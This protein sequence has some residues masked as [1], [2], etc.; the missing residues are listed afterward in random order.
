MPRLLVKYKD[1]DNADSAEYETD[2]NQ[3]L[4]VYRGRKEEILEESSIS[5]LDTGN[6]LIIR[7]GKKKLSLN[8]SELEEL[9][10]LLK[11]REIVEKHEFKLYEVKEF[12]NDS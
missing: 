10:V 1:F 2:G 5:T 11:Y 4:R 12:R 7:Q 8:Y 9:L 6:E 3:A